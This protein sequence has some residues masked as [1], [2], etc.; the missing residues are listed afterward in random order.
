MLITEFLHLIIRVRVFQ[1]VAENT[2]EDR[3]L[4]IQ[5][6]KELLIS[7]AFSGNKNAPKVTEKLG[8]LQNFLLAATFISEATNKVFF[9]FI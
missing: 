9:D 4:D 7:Q 5:K 6:E 8:S 3:V 1:L 2:V